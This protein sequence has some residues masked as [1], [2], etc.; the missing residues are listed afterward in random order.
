MLLLICRRHPFGNNEPSHR[1]YE[2]NNHFLSFFLFINNDLL[3]QIKILIKNE[4]KNIHTDFLD[5][6]LTNRLAIE[7]EFNDRHNNDHKKKRE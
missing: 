1:L 6:L 3:A 5:D 2:T 7:I 4:K